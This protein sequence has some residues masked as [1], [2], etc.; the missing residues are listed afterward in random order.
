M[1]PSTTTNPSKDQDKNMP[2]FNSHITL[3]SGIWSNLNKFFSK[4]GNDK[5]KKIHF[6]YSV[7]GGSFPGLANFRFLAIQNHTI[8]KQKS[9]FK[10]TFAVHTTMYLQYHQEVIETCQIQVGGR[11]KNKGN[12]TLLKDRKGTIQCHPM[13]KVYTSQPKSPTSC[14]N[15]ERVVLL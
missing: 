1:P 4:G 11:K 12:N 7:G 3:R 5:A 8:W 2:S 9:I 6:V 10:A 13:A 14:V 15:H